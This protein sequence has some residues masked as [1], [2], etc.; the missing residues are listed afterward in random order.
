VPLEPVT[1]LRGLG[2]RVYL[3]TFLFFVGDGAIIPIIALAAR[4]LGASVAV[5]GFVVA[6]RSLGSLA[7]DLPAGWII[8]R[9]GER[10]AVALAS[11]C[12]VVTL[13]GWMV[14]ESVTVFAALAFVQGSG[15]SVW[16]LARLAYVSEVVPPTLRGRALSTL[17]GT[18]R[19]GY[20]VGPFAAAGLTA[21]SG[22]DAVYALALGL[23]VLAAVLLFRYSSATEG[24]SSSARPVPVRRILAE[25]SSALLTT[26]IAALSVQALRT[27]RV[28]IVPLWADHIGLSAETASVLFGVS[29]GVE[30]LFVYPGGSVMDRYGRKAVAVPCLVLMSAGLAL[31]P[32][33]HGVWSMVLIAVLLG[34]GNG[35]SSG[36]NMTLGADLAPAVGRA[37]FL[38]V[39]RVFGDI[40][41]AGGPLAVAGVT[42]ALT[43]GDASVAV[44]V[45]GLAAAAYVA[46]FVPE[47]LRR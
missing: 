15:W 24:R 45:L 17:G 1:T 34:F 44:G 36:V 32:L 25:H 35:I 9:F 3:P 5:A 8:A 16:Q 40:G 13:A 20:F 22:F 43:L 39:W 42:A 41:T 27:A 14:T 29:L 47:T 11:G 33:A 26:G 21:A 38:G 23:S 7:F 18:V 46:R 12:F 28:A 30:V 37:E 19:V 2:L 10:A 6:L 4:D 31:L